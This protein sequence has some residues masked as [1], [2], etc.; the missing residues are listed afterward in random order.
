[1]STPPKDVWDILVAIAQII[2]SLA[3]AG[4]LWVTYKTLRELKRQTDLA[5]NPLLKI[6]Y[7]FTDIFPND[8]ANVNK[9]YLKGE[10]LENWRNIITRNLQQDLGSLND[11]FLIVELSNAGKS[12]ITS[13]SFDLI[14]DVSM[15]ANNVLGYKIEPTNYK[16]HLDLTSELSEQTSV[17]LLI[18]NVRYFPIFICEVTNVSYRDIRGIQYINFDGPKTTG[19]MS[20]EVLRPQE[21]VEAINPIPP[22]NVS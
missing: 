13:L 12:E 1:M 3:T 11:R 17:K 21:K 9:E 20:N 4:A 10:P 15:F 5:N 2:G 18:T 6:R 7:R 8:D 19:S 16:W 14:L 22:D